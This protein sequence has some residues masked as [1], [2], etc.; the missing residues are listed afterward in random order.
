MDI[1]PIVVAIVVAGGPIIG[2]LL[3]QKASE[4]RR[5]EVEKKE[6]EIDRKK[7]LEEMEQKT[8]RVISS[9]DGVYQ[10]INGTFHAML[11]GMPWP[12]WIK[13][14]YIDPDTGL[15]ETRMQYLNSHYEDFYSINRPDYIGH[16]DIE[17][18]GREI[19]VKFQNHDI[20]VYHEQQASTF[21]EQVMVDRKEVT[22]TFIKIPISS[23]RSHAVVGMLNV[24]KSIEMLRKLEETMEK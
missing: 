13:G 3:Q 1:V 9:V 17:Y 11:E 23:G 20:K 7:I 16:T 22:Q 4:K 19:G 5:R 14:V 18:W 10:Q 24:E 2:L 6:R 21:E 12:A 8:M 15:I